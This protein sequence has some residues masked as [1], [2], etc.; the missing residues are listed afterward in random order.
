[1]TVSPQRLTVLVMHAEPLVAIGLV[2][3]LRQQA[4]FR[5]FVHGTDNFDGEPID[6]VITD[7]QSGLGWACPRGRAMDGSE[8]RTKV[9]VLT[10]QYREQEIRI[11]LEAGVHGYLLLGCTTEELAASVRCLGRGSRYVCMAVAQRMADSL[12]REALTSREADVLRLLAQGHC[13]KAIARQLAIAIGTVKAH[14][15]AIMEKLDAASRT[16]AVSVAIERGLVQDSPRQTMNAPG[17]VLASGPSSSS[18]C[19]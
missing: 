12:T 4:D 9:M 10:T 3:A 7:Y 15:K 11:A 2:A 16:Q 17:N 6:V 14:V 18:I 5:V 19:Q 13:N 8:G 1:M